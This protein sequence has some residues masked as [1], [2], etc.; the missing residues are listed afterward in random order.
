[1]AY[2]SRNT[3]GALPGGWVSLGH[4]Q[5]RVWV[6]QSDPRCRYGRLSGYLQSSMVS[7]LFKKRH[8]YIKNTKILKT[9]TKKYKKHRNKVDD[10]TI[11]F[12]LIHLAV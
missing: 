2:R 8:L 7:G 12:T 10:Y 11:L 5:G 4:P 3:S 9:P 6:A 1:M